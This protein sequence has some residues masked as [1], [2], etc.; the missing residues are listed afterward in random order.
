MVHQSSEAKEV[1]ERANYMHSQEQKENKC[2]HFHV[3]P[4]TALHVSSSG[5]QSAEWCLSQAVSWSGLKLN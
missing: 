3:G 1:G 5:F 2:I 4:A